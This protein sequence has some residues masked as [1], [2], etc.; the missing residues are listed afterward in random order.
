[1]QFFY[2]N[3]SVDDRALSDQETLGL[4]AALILEIPIFTRTLPREVSGGYLRL[5]TGPL[6]AIVR[7]GQLW[8]ENY[9]NTLTSAPLH[10]SD[11][12]HWH[13]TSGR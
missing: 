3:Q 1:M 10:Q 4:E 6:S 12:E 8:V 5:V 2:R 9:L 13:L 11:K 7:H